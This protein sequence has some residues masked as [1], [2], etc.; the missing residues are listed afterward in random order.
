VSD[1][2]TLAAR[3]DRLERELAAT[4]TSKAAEEQALTL[5]PAPKPSQAASERAQRQERYRQHQIAWAEQQ[6]A[7]RDAW[8]EKNGAKIERHEAEMRE[9]NEAIRAEYR[10]QEEVTNELGAKLRK[11]RASYPHPPEAKPCPPLVQEPLESD[12]RYPVVSPEALE[13]ARRQRTGRP[14]GAAR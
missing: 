5:P 7:E 6:A 12:P 3:L 1:D 14:I 13:R 2:Q 10:R 9:V 4:K 11:L 8:L